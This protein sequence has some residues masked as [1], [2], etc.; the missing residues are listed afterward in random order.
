MQTGG[1]F[2]NNPADCEVLH[3]TMNDFTKVL[4]V[5]CL[6][7]GV[8]LFSAEGRA[9]QYDDDYEN[10]DGTYRLLL[11]GQLTPVFSVLLLLVSGADT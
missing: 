1:I 4:L 6:F 9:A 2:L 10:D 3:T 8:V 11:K 7:Y 5:V